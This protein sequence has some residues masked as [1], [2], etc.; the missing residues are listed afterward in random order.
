V[1]EDFLRSGDF[2]QF[3]LTIIGALLTALL[4]TVRAGIKGLMLRIDKIEMK[5]DLCVSEFANA[6]AN[7]ASHKKIWNRIETQSQRIG[8]LER[9][10]EGE[11]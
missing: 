7:D 10:I 11:Q 4:Y 2:S 6:T 5:H 8:V 3:L 1:I 9:K